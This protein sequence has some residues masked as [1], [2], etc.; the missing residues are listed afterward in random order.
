MEEENAQGAVPVTG[1]HK[2]C[3]SG[4]STCCRVS[5]QNSGGGAGL[6]APPFSSDRGGSTP[7]CGALKVVGGIYE[8]VSHFLF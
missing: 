7:K 5:G 2:G 4:T 3:K 8:L 1:Q 6:G